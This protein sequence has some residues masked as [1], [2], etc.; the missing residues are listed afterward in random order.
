MIKGMCRRCYQREYMRA[1]NRAGRNDWRKNHLLVRKEG[2]AEAAWEKSAA[3][4]KVIKQ[5]TAT[6]NRRERGKRWTAKNRAAYLRRL[7]RLACERRGIT[8]EQYD[9]ML[10]A[11]KGLCA[12]C[13]EP[14]DHARLF[15]DHCHKTGK[16]RGLLC[17][18]C[19]RGLG[20]FRDRVDLFLSAVSYLKR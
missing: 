2:R 20:H 19:N 15:I 8:L 18:V 4:L 17:S 11:Q 3:A 13:E 14:P 7:L 6:K 1:Y 9:Q 12:I 5:N 10:A 16:V